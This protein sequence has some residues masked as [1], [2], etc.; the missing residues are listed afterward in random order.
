VRRLLR[1]YG[2]RQPSRNDNLVRC[3]WSSGRHMGTDL[4]NTG[5]GGGGGQTDKQ[6]SCYIK[7]SLTGSTIWEGRRTVVEWQQCLVKRAAIEGPIDRRSGQQFDLEA[8]ILV[9]HLRGSNKQMNTNLIFYLLFLG[10]FGRCKCFVERFLILIFCCGVVFK[11]PAFVP[12]SGSFS[13]S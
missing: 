4:T 8:R 10:F 2:C 7:E 11:N 5:E 1:F 6:Y 3:I 13:S 12:N 9:H